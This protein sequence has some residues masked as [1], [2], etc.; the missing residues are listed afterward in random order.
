MEGLS[1]PA[2]SAASGGWMLFGSMVIGFLRGSF[3]L[4]VHYDDAVKRAER[5]ESLVWRTTEATE[6][7]VAP[8]EVGARVLSKFPY[9]AAEEGDSE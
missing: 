2:I 3:V 4:K 7:L 6:K 1:W 8:V 9:P 5:F